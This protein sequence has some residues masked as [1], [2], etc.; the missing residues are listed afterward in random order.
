MYIFCV[1]RGITLHYKYILYTQ[2]TQWCII[3]NTILERK[4]TMFLRN[5]L[6]LYHICWLILY[7]VTHACFLPNGKV[8]STHFVVYVCKLFSQTSEGDIAG[9]SILKIFSLS[10]YTQGTREWYWWKNKNERQTD[11]V[12]TCTMYEKALL[13][14]A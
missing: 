1:S 5:K 4:I 14:I 7:P 9:F 10:W 13:D 2:H 8:L 12:K 11:A 3:C 6:H